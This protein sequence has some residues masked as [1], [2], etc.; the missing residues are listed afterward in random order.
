MTLQ[1]THIQPAVQQYS[2]QPGVQFTVFVYQANLSPLI[3]EGANSF[4]QY[5]I[6]PVSTLEEISGSFRQVPGCLLAG[7]EHDLARQLEAINRSCRLLPVVLVTSNPT[8][9]FAVKAARHGAFG[10]IHNPRDIGA[11]RDTIQR[12][13]HADISGASSPFKIRCRISK[14]TSKERQ[15]I[16]RSLHGNTTKS[17]AAELNVCHQT[18]DKHKKRALQK[19]KATSVVDLMNMLEKSRFMTANRNAEI[20]A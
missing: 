6:Q 18:I 20:L 4:R 15:V 12:A 1:H 13:C 14:L 17:I 19:L 16:H 8:Y 10:I 7:V 5:E 3:F 2:P 11:I 9:D